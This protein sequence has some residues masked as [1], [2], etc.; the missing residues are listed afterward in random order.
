M[1]YSTEILTSRKGGFAVFWLAATVGSKG[2]TAVKK[3]SKAEVLKSNVV[4]ACEKVIAPEEPLAL[5]L[6]SNLMMG[7]ARVYQQQFYFYASDVTHV[8]QALKKA[9]TEASMSAPDLTLA[10][11]IPLPLAPLPLPPVA[12]LKA[13]QAA[14]GI[15]LAINKGIAVVGFNPDQLLLEQDWRFPGEAKTGE[16]ELDLNEGEA[17][18]SPVETREGTPASARQPTGAYQARQADI[19]LHE[20]Q[21]DDYLLQG[22]GGDHLFPEGYGGGDEPIFAEGEQGL[23]EGLS[24]ELDALIHASSARG[25]SG[26]GSARG[27]AQQRYGPSSSAMGGVDDFIQQDYGGGYEGGDYGGDFFLPQQQEGDEYFLDRVRQE[28]EEARA[29]LERSPGFRRS[30]T[31]LM[32][33]DLPEGDSTPSSTTRKRVSDALELAKTQAA[34]TKKQKDAKTKA[35]AQKPKKLKAIPID[36]NTELSDEAFREMRNGYGERMRVEREKSEKAKEDK[37]AHKRAMDLVF[38]PPLMFQG[39]GLADFWNITMTDMMVPFDGGKSGLK[40]RRVTSPSP[41]SK[42]KKKAAGDKDEDDYGNVEQSRRQRE[43]G[44]LSAQPQQGQGGLFE[45]FGLGEQEYGGGYEGEMEYGRDL[46]AD[47]FQDVEQGRDQAGS[48]GGLTGSVARQGAMPWAQE[49]ATSDVGGAFPGGFGG[50]SSQAGGTRVSLDTP[51]QHGG[52]ERSRAG[53]LRPSILGSSPYRAGSVGLLAEQEG[54]FEAFEQRPFS[55]SPSP[56]P[57]G[58]H[59]SASQAHSQPSAGALESDSLKFLSFARRHLTLLRQTS[60]DPNDQLLFS[61]IVPV[62]DT[63]AATAAQAL[64]HVLVLATRGVVRVGQEEG[65]GEISVDIL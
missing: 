8:H 58:S 3:L 33:L 6:S 13:A 34:Q 16:E 53:S 4:R 29:R 2:G 28:H 49:L 56:H 61:D 35:A 18:L 50:P 12:P 5:R 9:I 27:A 37:E 25:G 42:R 57:N 22:L 51:L 48:E 10:P 44:R 47:L 1:F 32:D 45:Q 17:F 54:Q 7:I 19:T 36:R 59:L 14:Q 40:K 24:P 11:E 26:V 23:L 60:G 55:R 41:P 52:F 63:N 46:A 39:P 15:D 38:G 64:Y 65:Y 30:P 31:P 20:P 21:L 62:A 43:E